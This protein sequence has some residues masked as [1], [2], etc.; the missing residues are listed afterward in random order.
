[1]TQVVGV[2]ASTIALLAISAT[3]A[4][5]TASNCKGGERGV[6]M[7]AIGESLKVKEI[8]TSRPHHA[9]SKARYLVKKPGQGWKKSNWKRAKQVTDHFDQAKWKVNKSFPHGTRICTE[10]KGDSRKPCI[11]VKR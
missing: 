6:C 3:Q 8:K 11:T 5:A 10:F 1:M 4:H 9:G 2:G 7:I